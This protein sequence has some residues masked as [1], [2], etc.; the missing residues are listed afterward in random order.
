MGPTSPP[1]PGYPGK[2]VEIRGNIENFNIAT[3][4]THRNA[5]SGGAQGEGGPSGNFAF[6]LF[7]FSRF[8]CFYFPT[9]FREFGPVALRELTH[10][11]LAAVRS[12]NAWFS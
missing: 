4:R 3:H 7:D 8:Y 2:F 11:V 9:S 10:G 5:N 12:C 6:L 1:S